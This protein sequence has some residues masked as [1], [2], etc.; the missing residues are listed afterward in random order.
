MDTVSELL[1][2]EEDEEEKLTG[3]TEKYLRD[4]DFDEEGVEV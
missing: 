1:L 2:L 4:W 3:S